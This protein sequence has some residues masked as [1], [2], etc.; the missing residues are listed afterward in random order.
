MTEQQQPTQDE[1]NDRIRAKI[2]DEHA[3]GL[4]GSPDEPSNDEEH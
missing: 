3:S 1:I 2:W 4:D